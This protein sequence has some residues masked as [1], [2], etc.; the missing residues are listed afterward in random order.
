MASPT[1]D[2]FKTLI[3]ILAIPLSLGMMIK[4]RAPQFADKMERPVRIA[5]SVFLAGGDLRS[6]S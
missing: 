1:A 4:N 3:V 2:I 6:F 5:S